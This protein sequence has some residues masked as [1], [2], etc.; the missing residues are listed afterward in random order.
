MTNAQSDNGLLL[1]GVIGAAKGLKGEVRIKSFTTEPASLGAFGPLT[2]ETG[3]VSF[4]LKIV[5]RHK[6]QM[7]VRIEGV[8]D[9]N[10]AEALNGT[11]LYMRRDQLPQPD[12]DEYYLADLVGLKAVLEDGSDWGQVILADDFGAGAVLEIALVNGPNG[13]VAFTQATVPEVDLKAGRMVVIPPQGL[14]EPGVPEPVQNGPQTGH[15]EE[16]A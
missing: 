15:E 10:A 7:V 3:K 12:E 16:E 1:V 4:P 8:K 13:M 11:K 2:D 5:G 6:E 9:R 14:L